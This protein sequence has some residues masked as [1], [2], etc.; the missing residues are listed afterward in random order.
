MKINDVVLGKKYKLTYPD[1]RGRVVTVTFIFPTGDCEVKWK[2]G[3]T[4]LY[5]AT[6]LEA[7]E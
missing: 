5:H 4:D 1:V 6:W 2:S 7:I 3:K